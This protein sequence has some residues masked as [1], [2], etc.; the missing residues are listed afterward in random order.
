MPVARGEPGELEQREPAPA[1]DE[2]E[3]LQL[4]TRRGWPLVQEAPLPSKV[5]CIEETAN[6]LLRTLVSHIVVEDVDRRA[7]KR[8]SAT[9]QFLP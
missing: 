8:I 9:G 5:V 2:L 3:P 6:L 7:L 4:P 1:R